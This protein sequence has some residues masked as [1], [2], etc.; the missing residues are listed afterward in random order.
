MSELLKMTDQTRKR[1]YYLFG[2]IPVWTWREEITCWGI[3]ES[4]G[5]SA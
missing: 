2:F 4:Q 5:D 3:P 1:V